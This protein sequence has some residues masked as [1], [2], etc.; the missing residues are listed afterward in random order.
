[1]GEEERSNQLL[2]ELLEGDIN[3]EQKADVF[4]QLSMLHPHRD[5]Y[6][7]EA[8]KLYQALFS[9]TPKHSYKVQI[10]KLSVD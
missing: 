4:Y 5:T 9:E 1:M 3:K 7:Q 10:S 8:L 2:N 6:R